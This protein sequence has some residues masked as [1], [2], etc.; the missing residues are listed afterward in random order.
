MT[1]TTLENSQVLPFDKIGRIVVRW[2]ELHFILRTLFISAMQ[3]DLDTASAILSQAPSDQAQRKIIKAVIK[4]KIEDEGILSENK[5]IF[6]E[7]DALSGERNNF[8]HGLWFSLPEE[9]IAVPSRH[10]DRRKKFQNV[11]NDAD[12]LLEKI[13]NTQTRVFE[14]EKKIQTF[15]RTPKTR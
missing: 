1:N 2:N 15:W 8:I 3:T 13:S 10:G 5:K 12:N 6:S 4:S 14:L 7:I 9:G 11:D